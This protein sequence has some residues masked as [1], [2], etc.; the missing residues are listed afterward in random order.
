MAKQRNYTLKERYNYHKNIA[1]TGKKADG[2][3]VG[4]TSRVRHAN[5]AIK[6]GNKLNRFMG[7]VDIVENKK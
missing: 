7:A 1:D 2:T 4:L 3:K 6:L 5:S